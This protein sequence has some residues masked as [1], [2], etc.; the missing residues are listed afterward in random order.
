MPLW[1]YVV[2]VW[3]FTTFIININKAR[4]PVKIYE[5]Y[6]L[7]YKI[8]IIMTDVKG[9]ENTCVRFFDKKDKRIAHTCIL[10]KAGIRMA[11][12]G[13]RTSIQ[14]HFCHTVQQ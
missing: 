1:P 6:I 4:C 12:L 3:S 8:K 10:V 11:L 2:K 5:M 9:E 13:M 7:F 14:R